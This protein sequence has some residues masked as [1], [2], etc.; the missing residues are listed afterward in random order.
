[1]KLK[2][3]TLTFLIGLTAITGTKAAQAA[4]LTVVVDGVSN[5]R[6]VSFG[7]DGTLY[8]AE[9][10]I[11]GNGKCQASPSTIFQP[12]CAGNSGSVVKL[13]PDGQQSRIFQNFQSLAEQ[14][15]GNQGAG[16]QDLQF[17]SFGNAYLL[18]GF[19][20]YPGNRD[21]ETIALGA[22]FPIP[23]TQLATFP[24]AA[25]D[26]V[27]NTSN[28]AKLFK[29]DL[30]TQELTEIFDFGKYEIINNPD[31]GDV[32]TNPYDLTIS[33]DTAYVIDG[34]GNVAY[35]LKLDGSDAKAVAL[36]LNIITNPKLPP[37]PPGVELPPGLINFLPPDEAGNPR[38]TI[39]SVPTGGAI[40]PDGALYVGEY[41]GF[42]YPQ[43][44][45]RI[46]RIG[47]NGIP[48]VYAEGFNAI[49]ELTFDKQ[50][51]LLV[52]QFSDLSQLTS[53]NIQNL[54]G[55]LIQ[56]AP[57]GTRTT[58]VAAGEGLESADGLAIGPDNQIYVTTR[59]VGPG[60]GQVVR[61]DTTPVPEPASVLGLLAIGTIT[62][63]ARKGNKQKHKNS[64]ALTET[65]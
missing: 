4:S 8:V 17:D 3:F 26:E 7:P 57:D 32:V 55:S 36:P 42:P 15:S 11:G 18:T 23:P 40:G 64:K 22:N 65:I 25:P 30:I 19:A 14:P 43:D 39:Q 48:E 28:L 52:L 44:Q 54:P 50:G 2:Q 16:P 13:T 5:A 33:G 27:L 63:V 47:E 46:F 1:M 10:G 12:I 58:L 41:S 9:P 20:G 34:G 31:G 62:A 49:T 51:N 37:L 29:A 61:V 45:A 38:I 21:A 53:P 56:L 35:S 6:A 59:G 60:R 24:P